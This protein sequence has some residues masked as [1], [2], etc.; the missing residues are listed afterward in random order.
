MKSGTRMEAWGCHQGMG[1]EEEEVCPVAT[2]PLS[3]REY[4]G[5]SLENRC[6]SEGADKG[7]GQKIQGME[8]EGE[9]SPTTARTGIRSGH[10]KAGC[11]EQRKMHPGACRAWEDNRRCKGGREEEGDGDTH[12]S[13]PGGCTQ[14]GPPAGELMGPQVL[15]TTTLP[16]WAWQEVL[17]SC[18]GQHTMGRRSWSTGDSEVWPHQGAWE[19]RGGGSMGEWAPGQE[20]AKGTAGTQDQHGYPVEEG[21]GIKDRHQMRHGHSRVKRSPR[22]GAPA[23]GEPLSGEG[24]LGTPRWKCLGPSLERQVRAP[25]SRLTWLT[26]KQWPHAGV[27]MACQ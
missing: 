25:R 6:I 24:P 4:R 12:L 13:R 3:G 2:P 16:Q 10:R 1:K 20:V 15:D 22:S 18:R 5:Q 23:G 11:Q 26:W 8:S 21:D 7:R 9:Q 27:R 17:G 14:Q 19:D